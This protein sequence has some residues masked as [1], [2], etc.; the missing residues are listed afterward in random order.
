[1]FCN[2]CEQTTRGDVCHQ[3]GACGKSPEVAALQ[4]LL[5]HCL[6]GLS[7]VA[8]QAKSL[9][10]TTYHT[11]EFTCDLLFSTLTNVNFTNSDFM[12]FVN[13]A[14]AM[15]ESLKLEIQA[16][17]NKFVESSINKF[18]PAINL[19]AQIQQHKD[20]EFDS[21]SHLGK[22]VDIFSPK[23]TTYAFHALE[24]NQHN[25][26]LY[27]FSHEFLGHLD[28][29]DKTFANHTSIQLNL[30]PTIGKSILVSKHNS[31]VTAFR[32]SQ[33]PVTRIELV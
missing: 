18:Q 31:L 14:I 13:R 1:M 12:A 16:L 8:L 21:I 19:Q 29:Q 4:D 11:D 26:C 25:E 28:N 7:Q 6:R 24:L 20:L 30:V 27:T 2:Q 3:W 5:I 33:K 9:G 17:G 23:F 15:R 10:I 22:N 32:N